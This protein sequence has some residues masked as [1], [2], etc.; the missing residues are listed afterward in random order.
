MVNPIAASIRMALSTPA[1]FFSRGGMRDSVKSAMAQNTQGTAESSPA[2]TA[3]TEKRS[4]MICGS[5]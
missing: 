2:W 1:R 5:Q 4:L 3:L